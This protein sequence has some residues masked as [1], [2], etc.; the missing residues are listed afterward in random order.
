MIWA[1]AE[2]GRIGI[3][4]QRLAR[5]WSPPG[6]RP[7]F[8]KSVAQLGFDRKLVMSVG[9]GSPAGVA[10]LPLAPGRWTS[11]ARSVAA[12]A[13]ACRHADRLEALADAR[14]GV[15]AFELAASGEPRVDVLVRAAGPSEVFVLE[16]LRFERAPLEVEGHDPADAAR[17]SSPRLSQ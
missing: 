3:A 1:R 11:D 15:V 6:S 16:A 10:A 14:E 7:T 12:P 8:A 17:S 9:A 2:G 4:A 13:P 5:S